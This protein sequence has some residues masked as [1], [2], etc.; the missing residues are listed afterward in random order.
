MQAVAPLFITVNPAMLTASALFMLSMI[1]GMDA[2]KLEAWVQTGSEFDLVV[3][4]ASHARPTI[5]IVS[6]IPDSDRIRRFGLE[7]RTFAS[8][9]LME[10][11]IT[12]RAAVFGDECQRSNWT[13]PT[14]GIS[15]AKI[16][17]NHAALWLNQ[18]ARDFGKFLAEG[19][20]ETVINPQVVSPV[21][22]V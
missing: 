10:A 7:G 1:Q 8:N 3:R 16:D 14:Q 9:D 5:R 11:Y 17:G 4:G 18:Q 21:G 2:A 19:C 13:L 20:F 6:E 15:R 22:S 12:R